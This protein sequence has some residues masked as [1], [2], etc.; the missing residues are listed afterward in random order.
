M[1][2]LDEYI[3]NKYKTYINGEDELIILLVGYAPTRKIYVM[4]YANF[5]N[6]ERTG[7]YI[8]Y[9]TLGSVSLFDEWKMLNN[10]PTVNITYT[11]RLV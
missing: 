9:T 1:Q 3:R 5:S 10:I 11:K 6:T 7:Y 8:G 4:P 2:Y